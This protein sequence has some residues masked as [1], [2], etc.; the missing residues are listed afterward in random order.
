MT[1][2]AQRAFVLSVLVLLM[3]A[4]RVNHFAAIPDASWAVFFI[5]GFYLRAWTRWAFPVLMALAVLVDWIVIRRSGLDFWQHYCVSPGYWML[6]P[7][8]FAMWSGGMLLRGG[9]HSA[10]WAAL[11]K[12]ALLLVA[13]VAVCHLFAQGGFYW[14]SD[15]VAAPTVDGWAKNYGDWFLP[16]LRTAAV[17]V[18]LA[19]ALQ[20]ATEQVGKLLQARRDVLH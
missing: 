1:S 15:S 19:A 16:Y 7:A 4:T 12:G 2:T 11:G 9:Y 6:L 5:G 13:A 3:A 10:T 14:T 18:G 8:Y 17:Y 20:L